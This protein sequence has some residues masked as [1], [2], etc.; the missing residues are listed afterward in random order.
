MFPLK[1]ENPTK[2]R[3]ILTYSLIA[4]NVGI[5]LATLL[6]GT[7]DE[8]IWAY[9]MRPAEI[10]HGI[11]LHTMIT[12]MFLHGGIFHILFNM[13]YL[14]IF[15]DNVED[16]LGGKGFLIFY[17]AAGIAGDLVYALSDPSSMI[18]T[19]GASGAISGLLGA[20]VVFYPWA[21]VYTAVVFFYFL[22]IVAVPALVVIGAWFALQLLSSSVTWLSGVSTGT[23]Y[24]AH[25]GGFLFGLFAAMIIKKFGK[26]KPRENFP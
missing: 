26:A 4:V 7:F 13:W 19:I 16:R 11:S 14:W 24:W 18:P 2:R 22:R 6:S 8:Y 10:L 9:G 1:D 20:Y 17:L 23:A 3:P 15:G 25:I 12:S 5:F 21:N